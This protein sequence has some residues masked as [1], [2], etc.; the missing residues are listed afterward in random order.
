M[1]KLYDVKE[2]AALLKTNPKTVYE[3]MNSGLLPYLI[4]G[5]RKVRS[6]SLDKFLAD[7]DGYDLTDP[8]QPKRIA[9]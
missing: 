9:H 8:A 2:T 7:Y 1:D 6:T 5:R 3:L 4:I